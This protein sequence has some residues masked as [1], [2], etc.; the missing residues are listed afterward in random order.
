MTIESK[1][2]IEPLRGALTMK[3]VWTRVGLVMAAA[4]LVAACTAGDDSTSGT[5][6]PTTAPAGSAPAAT[7]PAPGVT[8]DAVRVGVTFVDEEALSAS[9][10]E[11]QLGDN[12]GAYQALFDQINAEGGIN[13]RQIEPVY[14]PIDPTSST[15]AE[16]ACVQ[17]TED[18]DV[19][20]VIGFFLADAVRCPVATHATAVVGGSMTPELLADAQAPWLTNLADTDFPVAILG[21]MADAGELDGT[22]G[23]FANARDQSVAEEQIV[24][25]LEDLD[26][27]VAEVGIVDAPAGDQ[28]ALEANVRTIAERFDS[29]GVDTVVLVGASGQDW[30]ANLQED[31]SYRPALLFLD[32]AA[33][34]AFA[35]NAATTDTSVLDGAIAGGGFGPNQAI[36]EEMA[37]C[38]TTITDAGVELPAPE[39][40]ADDPNNQTFQPAFA[41]CPQVAILQAWLEAAGQ[42]LN[43]GTLAAVLEGGV[44]VT[45]PGDPSPP[46]TFG[47]PPDAD[48]NPDAYLYRWD[49]D[50][51]ELVIAD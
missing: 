35:S 26:I 21:A 20:V 37:D 49:T 1:V 12:E 29:A 9:G 11:L 15:P 32:Q 34:T 33:V 43:Y 5:T 30:P 41:A 28:A 4:A 18:E 42:D 47:L 22:V 3:H 23:V 14:A 25:A 8:D 39:D 19:F 40:V 36:Y 44:E 7:G 45:A 16:E 10:L 51:Q 50:A 24:P 27:D 31:D 2:L 46:A 48:G 17:L 38:V 6:A 13:G